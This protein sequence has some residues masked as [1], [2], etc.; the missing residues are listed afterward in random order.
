VLD[1]SDNVS[2]QLEIAG[3]VH[4]DFHCHTQE[5]TTAAVATRP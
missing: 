2:L 3:V 5:C 4:L 1:T